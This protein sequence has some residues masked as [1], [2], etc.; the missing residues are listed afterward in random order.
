M[1]FT[2][3]CKKVSLND[4]VKAYAEKQISKLDR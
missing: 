3:T 2:F 1:K 4:A